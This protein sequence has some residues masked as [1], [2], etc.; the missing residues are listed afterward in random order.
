MEKK[1]ENTWPLCFAD[2]KECCCQD[3]KDGEISETDETFIRHSWQGD[4]VVIVNVCNCCLNMASYDY[5]DDLTEAANEL[6]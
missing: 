4:K 1:E 6:F 3:R 2:C 5:A